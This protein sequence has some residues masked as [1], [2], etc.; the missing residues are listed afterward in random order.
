MRAGLKL[1]SSQEVRKGFTMKKFL[2]AVFV[3]LVL[4]IAGISFSY[5][6]DYYVSN[7]GNDDNPGTSPEL[8]WQTISKVNNFDFKPGDVVHFRCGDSWREQ[9]MPVKGN[10]KGYI[11]YTSY[12]EGPKPVLYGSISKSKPSDWK[13]EGNNIWTINLGEKKVLSTVEI[14]LENLNFWTKQNLA[15]TRQLSSNG[16]GGKCMEFDCNNK[17]YS[18]YDAQLMIDGL[19]IKNGKS[20]VLSFRAKSN[21]DY[22][23]PAIKLMQRVSP[24]YECTSYNTDNSPIITDQWKTYKILYEA[25][26]NNSDA[27]ITLFFGTNFTEGMKLYIDSVGFSEVDNTDIRFDVGNVIFNGKECGVKV[28]QEA[29]LKKQNDFYYDEKTKTV[30]VY[31]TDNP[32][33]LYNSIE[34]A[35]DKHIVDINYR[36]YVQIENLDLK[37]GGSCGIFGNDTHHI[38]IHNC[39]ISYIGGALLMYKDGTPIRY[40]NGVNFMNNAHDNIVKGCSIWEIY[41]SGVTNQ[42]DAGG[43]S[44]YNISYKDNRIWNAEWSFE[45]WNSNVNGITRDIYFC[46]NICKDAGVGWGHSQRPDPS[47]IHIC[48]PDNLAVT[49]N[50]VIENNVFDYSTSCTLLVGRNWNDLNELVLRNN[51]YYLPDSQVIIS[52]RLSKIFFARDFAAYQKETGKDVDSVISYQ[53]PE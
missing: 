50:I 45:Y 19:K 9:L 29:Q 48:L 30:K 53:I 17:S 11:T 47:G 49:K 24:W 20:Y 4:T 37:N 35:L 16:S 6:K 39:N 7:S 2:L 44:Q 38:K 40:G 42:A 36:S 22:K 31:S 41:D 28:F 33:N 13:D 15:I 14:S 27:R 23:I 32:A 26:R 43:V 51:K 1:F 52:W 5:A 18:I 34:L 8:S 21:K 10:E 25:D 12:G 46:N 3:V